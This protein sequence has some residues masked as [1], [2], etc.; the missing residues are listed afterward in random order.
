VRIAAIAVVAIEPEDGVAH[1][2]IYGDESGK[3]AQSDLV[4]FCGYVGHASEFERVM[5]EWNNCRFAW[6]V[7]PVHMR[8]ITNPE[9]NKNGEWKNVR[10]EW[11]NEWEPKRDLMLK[12]FS[13]IILNSNLACAGSVIDSAHL[14]KM[15]E[16]PWKEGMRDPVFLGFH[17]LLMESLDKIDRINEELSV[18]IIVDDDP[19][20]AKACYD[21]LNVLKDQFPRVRRRISAITFGN[22]EHYPALQMADMIA[23]E[24]RSLMVRRMAKIDEPPS[25]IYTALT[26]RQIHQPKFWSATFLDRIALSGT[27]R[28]AGD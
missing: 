25:S 4:S 7:P 24:A 14:R 2:Y 26:R 13:S 8:F 27:A 17:T 18:A 1:F 28:E 15:P 9:R 10:E 5:A 3:L 19:Q 16:S 20:Y 21:L 12:E 6:G 23:F 22:D 11:G